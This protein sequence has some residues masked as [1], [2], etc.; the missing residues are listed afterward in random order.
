MWRKKVK[1]IS[2]V[3]KRKTEKRERGWFKQN[4]LTLSFLLQKYLVQYL[5]NENL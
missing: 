2:I 4:I 1:G 5:S 3:M